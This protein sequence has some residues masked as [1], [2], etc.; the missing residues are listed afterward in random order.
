MTSAP[1]PAIAWWPIVLCGLA[2][3]FDGYDAQML[4]MAIPLM[5][6]EFHVMP[7]SL[8]VLNQG[9]N[10]LETTMIGADGNSHGDQTVLQACRPA[11]SPPAPVPPSAGLPRVIRR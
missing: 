5:A 2:V 7:I 9:R 4:A 11:R 3:V 8:E 6:K 10:G 1:T